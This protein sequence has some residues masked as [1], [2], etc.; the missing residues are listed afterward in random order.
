MSKEVQFIGAKHFAFTTSRGREGGHTVTD[1]LSV[2]SM[3]MISGGFWMCCLQCVSLNF[4]L[5]Y[6]K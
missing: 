5:F 4:N 2:L 6:L 3:S 1:D